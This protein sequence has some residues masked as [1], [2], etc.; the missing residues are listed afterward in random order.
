MWYFAENTCNDQFERLKNVNAVKGDD[1]S[2]GD[3]KYRDSHKVDSDYV[4]LGV[5]MANVRISRAVAV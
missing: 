2:P 4:D 1:N 3:G 5:L